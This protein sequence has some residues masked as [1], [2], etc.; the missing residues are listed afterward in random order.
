MLR[1]NASFYTQRCNFYPNIGSETQ[2]SIIVK[3]LISSLF[4]GSEMRG[5]V[6]LNNVIYSPCLGSETVGIII[7][8]DVFYSPF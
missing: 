8:K 6:I 1:N 4:L 2:G 5:F 7:L 3:N